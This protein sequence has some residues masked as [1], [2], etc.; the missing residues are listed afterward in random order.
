MQTS[1]MKSLLITF[2]GIEGCGK[3][4]QAKLLYKYLLS[5]GHSCL[6]TREP[7]GTRIGDKIR[8]LLLHSGNSELVLK[9]ELFLY[10]ASRCQL[11]EEAIL[12]AL[13][14]GDLV[15]CDRFIDSTVVYQGI[16][17][18]IELD[19]I[20]ELNYIATS[21]IIPDLTILI[22]CPVEIG[23]KRTQT[24]VK[25]VKS[26]N[27]YRRFEEKELDFH[28]KVRKGYLELC[29]KDPERIK[30]IDGT[31]GIQTIHKEIVS[32]VNNRLKRQA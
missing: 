1:K 24:R 18:G 5:E 21:G 22:D 27:D 2:E 29:E 4:T 8:V 32:I 11:M 13:K 30:R 31:K 12:P 26:G 25:K 9:A 3:T 28:Y 6:L 15:I 17:Q 16:V 14:R 19:L 20:K 23:L 10:L 7:G